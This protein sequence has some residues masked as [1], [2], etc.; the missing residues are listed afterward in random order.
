MKDHSAE[1][2]EK[3]LNSTDGMLPTEAPAF[4]YTRLMA[5]M[6]K[7][8]EDETILVRRPALAIA[9]LSFFVL[10]NI[11]LLIKY[12][13]QQSVNR[14]QHSTLDSFVSN[15]NLDNSWGN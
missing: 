15:Y 4:F 9:A 5:R 13:Q 1:R 14:N 11:F 6:Q 8:Q 2:I 10:L 7:E 3:V 12:N